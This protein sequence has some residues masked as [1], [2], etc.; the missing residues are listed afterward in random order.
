M[1]NI[2]SKMADSIP[3]ALA[4]IFV[5]YMF[6]RAERERD[7]ARAQNAKEKEIENKAHQNEMNQLW[8]SYLKSL[9]E[10]QSEAMQSIADALAQ[11]ERAAEERYKKMHITQDLIE[12]V[13]NLAKRKT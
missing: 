7:E 9:I 2:L 13:N 1:D 12:T 8:A 11:H 4:V 3:S 5:V 6:L 10:K